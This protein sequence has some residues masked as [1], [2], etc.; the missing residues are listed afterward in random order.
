MAT[1]T[2]KSGGKVGVSN[3]RIVSGNGAKQD[4]FEMT[5]KRYTKLSGISGRKG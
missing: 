5:G 3:N 2:K 4:K 1:K